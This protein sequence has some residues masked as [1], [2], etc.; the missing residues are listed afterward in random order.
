MVLRLEFCLIASLSQMSKSKPLD[1]GI[2]ERFRAKGNRSGMIEGNIHRAKSFTA[3]VKGAN[4]LHQSFQHSFDFAE[5][6]QQVN[7]D[8]FRA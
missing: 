3:S 2:L 4:I 1:K 8:T 7:L 6:V 5:V